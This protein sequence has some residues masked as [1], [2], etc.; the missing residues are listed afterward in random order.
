MPI[1]TDHEA[2]ITTGTE[3][4]GLPVTQNLPVSVP[5]ATAP[6]S[7]RPILKYIGFGLLLLLLG[8][9]GG[10]EWW[11]R[12]QSALPAGI[13][14]G[15]GRIEADEIDIDTKFAGRIAELF[16]D[17][18]DMVTGGQMLARMDTRDLEAMRL[19]DRAQVAVAERAIEENTANIAQQKTQIL[20]AQQQLARSNALLRQGFATHELVDQRQQALDGAN[21]G[22]KSLEAKLLE[23]ERTVDAAKHAVELDDVN[24]TDNTLVAP[25]PGRIQYRV[26]N[27]G[28]VLPA[29]GKVFVMLDTAYVY[30]DI[31]VPTLNAGKIKLGSDARIVLDALPTHPLPATVTFL[32]TAAQFTPKDVETQTERDRLMFRLRVHVDR[33][34]L[35]AHAA[36]VRTGLPGVTYVKLDPSLP[37]PQFLQ[38][39]L[40]K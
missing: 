35:V 20:L 4:K 15:N 31:Y 19:R 38:T 14:F 39:D 11:K 24:I 27:T 40:T 8:A 12:T 2:P 33:D 10:Y 30:M 7:K 22:L 21:A 36:S 16:V 26:A 32:A 23:A 17:E 34:L 3:L 13:V 5:P 25:R 9:G 6:K 29:G 1:S 28:E 37:W 18:G